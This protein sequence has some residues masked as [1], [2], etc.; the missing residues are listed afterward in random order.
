[1][2]RPTNE[3]RGPA[4]LSA[5]AWTLLAV[6]AA[7]VLLGFG[8]ALGRWVAFALIL[9]VATLLE[10][11]NRLPDQT[12]ASVRPMAAARIAVALAGAPDRLRRLAGLVDHWHLPDQGPDR[13][14]D[15]NGELIGLSERSTPLPVRRLALPAICRRA[16]PTW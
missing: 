15:P 6:V 11:L 3:E 1:V 10:P 14:A 2:L 9:A 16:R 8:G 12:T 13:R 5:R 7:L 4:R